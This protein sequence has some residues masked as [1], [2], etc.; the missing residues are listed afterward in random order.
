MPDYILSRLEKAHLQS[1]GFPSVLLVWVKLFP[2]GCAQDSRRVPIKTRKCWFWIWL[3]S[4]YKIPEFFTISPVLTSILMICRRNRG[5]PSSLY[6]TGC[7]T[8]IT[9]KKHS[10]SGL[11]WSCP[12]ADR[13]LSRP[14]SVFRTT[15]VSPT[16]YP[17][18][19]RFGSSRVKNLLWS[20]NTKQRTAK[21]MLGRQQTLLLKAFYT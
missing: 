16:F 14:T 10:R 13:G 21:P 5:D 2:V 4:R 9:Y 3:R 18:R 19:L 8:S 7:V 6:R 17:D 20:I 15:K 12:R 1:L 11:A